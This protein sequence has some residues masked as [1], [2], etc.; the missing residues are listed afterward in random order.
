MIDADISVSVIVHLV[1][2]LNLQCFIKILE[3]TKFDINILMYM[4]TILDFLFTQ[5]FPTISDQYIT[6]ID[7]SPWFK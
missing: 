1:Q 5:M 2:D 7:R 6:F 3:A 4:V